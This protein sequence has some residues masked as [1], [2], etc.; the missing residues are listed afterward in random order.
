MWLDWLFLRLYGA[1]QLARQLH[2]P[3]TILA[4]F[5]SFLFRQVQDAVLLRHWFVYFAAS[6]PTAL[7]GGAVADSGSLSF[8]PNPL[9]RH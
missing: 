9:P 1:G 5:R 7:S 4:I 6:D 2:V 3:G 8:E